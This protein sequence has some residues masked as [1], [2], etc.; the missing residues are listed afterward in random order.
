MKN[1]IIGLALIF[2]GLAMIFS[3]ANSSFGDGMLPRVLFI[4]G[5]LVAV[6]GLFVGIRGAVHA[7]KRDT[8]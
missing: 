2:G 8:R 3:T 1:I 4:G 5:I 7:G 6:I